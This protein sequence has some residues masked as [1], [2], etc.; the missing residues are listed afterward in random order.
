MRRCDWNDCLLTCQIILSLIKKLAETV[1]FSNLWIAFAAS[2]LTL[3]TY[4]VIG[5][6]INELVVLLVFLATFSV[7][8][9]QRLIKHY[10]QKKNYSQRH[11]W[12]YKHIKVLT[13]LVALSS[14]FS[15][16]L[17]FWLYS[18]L[19]FISLLPFSAISVLYAVSIF[20]KKRA[21]RDFPF[22]KIFLIAITWAASSVI[23]PIIELSITIN[24]QLI[25]LLLFNLLFIIAIAIPFDIRD[26]KLDNLNTKT[27]PQVFGVNNSVNFSLTLIIG[28]FMLAVFSFFTLGQIIPLIIS[29]CL[30][31]L[32]KKEMPE[33]Y[34]SGILDGTILLFPLFNFIF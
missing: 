25:S 10:F 9:L 16:G 18:I 24:I 29:F 28:C 6:P 20:S 7:Y 13:L 31:Y 1:V 22:I 21:L 2:G 32:S 14:T 26:L 34:Y 33:L 30:L 11:S 5:K 3:N 12:I 19:D 27:I 4:L 23:L 15:L 17:F 8:N